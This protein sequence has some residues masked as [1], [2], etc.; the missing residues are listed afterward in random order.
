MKI[1]LST[2]GVLLISFCSFSQA[3]KTETFA[4]LYTTGEAWDTTKQFHEQ[5]F[6]A[7]HSAHLG[8]LR[9]EKR[10][11]LGGRYSDTGLILLKA[12]DEKEAKSCCFKLECEQCVGSA[13]NWNRKF[14]P[15]HTH[16]NLAGPVLGCCR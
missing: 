15:Y 13:G 8:A 14:C 9:K 4:I 5:K 12:K 3:N 6:F 11:T 10:I 2:F 7:E 16:R 1:I